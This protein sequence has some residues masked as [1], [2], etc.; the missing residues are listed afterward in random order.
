LTLNMKTG[1]WTA[2]AVLWSAWMYNQ[3]NPNQRHRLSRQEWSLLRQL[4]D[5]LTD[6][7]VGVADLRENRVKPE[8]IYTRE[9]IDG[10]VS[11][12]RDEVAGIKEMLKEERQNLIK[13]L[14][15]GGT[16]VTVILFVA[17]HLTIH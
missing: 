14:G 17:Q 16:A 8:Q 2:L 11:D 4:A 15:L 7:K 10:K 12:I 3:Q 1:D 13:L 6:L 5:D 9:V